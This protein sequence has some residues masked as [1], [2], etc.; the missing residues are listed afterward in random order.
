MPRTFFCACWIIGAKRITELYRLQN[1][2]R[3]NNQTAVMTVKVHEDDLSNSYR[4][5]LDYMADCV[6]QL[7]ERVSEQVTTRR[8]RVV[9]YRGSVHSH[10]EYPFALTN[11]GVWIIP[12]TATN[13]RHTALGEP[14]SSGVSGLD[15]LLG[16]GYRRGS[17]TLIAGTSG[18]G[19]TTFAAS[20]TR[21]ATANGKRVFYLNFEESVDAMLSCMLS[22]GIDLRPALDSGK[23]NFVSAMPESQGMGENILSRHSQSLSSSAPA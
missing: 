21:N 16:G 23:L 5:F 14:V 18:T 19:K 10:N 17:C 15:V 9:K 11:Q 12:I 4:E 2:L 7:D 8:I 3:D 1:W 20:F 22:P 6:I 13:L